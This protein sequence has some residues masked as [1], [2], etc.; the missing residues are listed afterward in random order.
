MKKTWLLPFAAAIALV[1]AP[2]VNLCAQNVYAAIHGSVTDA[3]GALIPNA[4]VTLTNIST[5]T[6]SVANH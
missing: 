2:G 3:S 5:G 1:A 6:R 4:K